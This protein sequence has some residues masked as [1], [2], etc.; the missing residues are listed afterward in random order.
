MKKI[1]SEK[2]AITILTLVSLV[3]LTTFLISSYII[4][5][6]KNLFKNEHY[7]DICM[8][9]KQLFINYIFYKEQTKTT[10]NCIF[11]L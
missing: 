9:L 1:K 2:G 6:N 3:F 8:K 7:F 4:N 11:I 5:F 10:T